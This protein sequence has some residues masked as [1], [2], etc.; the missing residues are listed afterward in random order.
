MPSGYGFG[1]EDASF[2]VALAAP[3]VAPGRVSAVVP[4]LVSALVSCVASVIDEG[5]TDAT[6]GPDRGRRPLPPHPGDCHGSISPARI[7]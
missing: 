2:V 4:V 7:A 1:V 5:R 6:R 3:S